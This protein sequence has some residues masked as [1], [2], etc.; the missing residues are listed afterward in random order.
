MAQGRQSGGEIRLEQIR[1]SLTVIVYRAASDSEAGSSSSPRF[2]RLGDTSVQWLPAVSDA[3]YQCPSGVIAAAHSFVLDP[4]VRPGEYSLALGDRN[5]IGLSAEVLTRWRDFTRPAEVSKKLG[6]EFSGWAEDNISYLKLLGDDV[7]LSPRWPGDSIRITGYWESQRT[8]SRHYVVSLY[9]LD[10]LMRVGG[11][12]DWTLGGHYPNVLWAPGE[13]VSET[14]A[15]PIDP[16]TPAGL[17][18]IALGLYDYVAP[19][20]EQVGAY[21]FLPA[22]TPSSPQPA[23]H[24][25]LGRVHVKDAAEGN[26][27]SHPL[28]VE[29]DNQIRLLGFDLVSPAADSGL[30]RMTSGETISLALHWQAI[31]QPKDDYTVFTQLIGP[32]GL[33]WGQQDNQP[34]GGRYPMTSWDVGQQ[35]VD[36]YELA[37]RS[38]APSGQ[39]RL[40]VGVYQL[41]TGQRLPAVAGD[42]TRLPGDAVPLATLTVE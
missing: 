2:L 28:L 17:Y 12:L 24:I 15:L 33:V 3:A 1:Q 29:L 38:G 21:N 7:D 19:D 11:Q 40:V 13:Y 35:V 31:R 30:A 23:D 25:N 22:T 9:L 8:M 42:G 5:D 34:Q 26:V 14:Y 6:T 18:T 36:R 20:G 32:D 39:Y 41:A 37:L 4:A 16:R 10:N 27:P